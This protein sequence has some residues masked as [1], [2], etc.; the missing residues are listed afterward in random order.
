MITQGIMYTML[1]MARLCKSGGVKAALEYVK[2]NDVAKANMLKLISDMLMWALF[3]SLFGF[4]LSPAY[5]EHKKN[6]ADNPVLVNLV[7]EILYKSSSRSYDQYKGPMNVIH[8]FGENMNPPFYSTPVQV[9][10]ETGQA[11]M[12]QKSWKYLL[13]DNTGLTR[14]FKD[15]GF[16][17]IKSQEQ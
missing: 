15:T 16:A 7:T 12:G 17:Y 10:S 6:A 14:S 9:L 3:A 1:D 2:G 5:K 13:F 11:L 4:V 8:F